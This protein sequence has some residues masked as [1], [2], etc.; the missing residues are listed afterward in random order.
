MYVF[1]R[2]VDLEFGERRENSQ[3][4]EL[5]YGFL[6]HCDVDPKATNGPQLLAR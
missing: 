5:M 1:E 2:W 3:K 6:I 4:R